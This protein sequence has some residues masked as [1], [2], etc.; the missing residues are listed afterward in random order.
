[1]WPRRRIVYG[2]D[3]SKT[4]VDLAGVGVHTALDP[5][6]AA[7][8]PRS[9]FVLPV[10]E[11]GSLR[12]VCYLD[13][14]RDHAFSKTSLELVGLLTTGQIYASIFIILA[15]LTFRPLS[16]GAAV[17][18][19]RVYLLNELD[20]QTKSLEHTVRFACWQD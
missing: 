6:F 15:C 20:A 12:G 18:I 14:S 17:A 3:G 10:I 4:I 13:S 19:E 16:A 5:F 9:V 11:E 1:M 8:R 7:H 2:P